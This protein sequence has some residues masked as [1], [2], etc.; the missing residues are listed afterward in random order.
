[1]A[2]MAR[3]APSLAAFA[4]LAAVG[5]LKPLAASPLASRRALDNDNASKNNSLHS[6]HKMN[7]SSLVTVTVWCSHIMVFFGYDNWF[8]I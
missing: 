2:F 6:E 5:R 3:A 7:L 1:M 8:T 4:T